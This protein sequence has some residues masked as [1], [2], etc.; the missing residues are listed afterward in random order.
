MNRSTD[1]LAAL[2]ACLGLALACTPSRAHHS[3]SQFDASKCLTIEG[4]VHRIE[5]SYPHVWLWVNVTNAKGAVEPWGFE[6]AS[7][8]VL[9]RVGWTKSTLKDGDKVSV[10]FSPLRDGRN[11]G[12]FASVKV[13]DGRDLLGGATACRPAK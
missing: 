3:Y 2:A 9:Q 4:T 13:P 1:R 5:W 12:A 6:G 7:P 8:V 11:G 10:R